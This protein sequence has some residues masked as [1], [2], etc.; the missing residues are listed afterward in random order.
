MKN[1]F[2]VAFTLLLFYGLPVLIYFLRN[3]D[4]S[5][6]TWQLIPVVVGCAMLLITQPTITK[7]DFENTKDRGSMIILLVTSWLGQWVLM[8]DWIFIRNMPDSQE[9]NYAFYLGLMGMITGLTFR[10]IAIRELKENFTNTVGKITPTLIKTGPYS[11]L[12]HPSYTG[13]WL[14]LVATGVTLQGFWSTMIILILITGSYVYRVSI[15][16][17]FLISVFGEK[18][19]DYQKHTWK[20]FPFIW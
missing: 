12:R 10:Y 13:A 16:E 3:H 11:Y 4:L 17:K 1:Y 8:I 15:E 7:A 6:T 2:K 19:T 5:L 14:F 20:L 9:N 18:Y